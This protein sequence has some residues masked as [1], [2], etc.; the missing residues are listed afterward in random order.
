MFDSID[1]LLRNG[2]QK[3][4]INNRMMH[5]SF[6]KSFHSHA[7]LV[8]LF[9]PG[10]PGVPD[11]Y[12]LFLAKIHSDLSY[13]DI[14][15]PSYVEMILSL[16][17]LINQLVAFVGLLESYYPKDTKF[18]IAGHSLGSYLTVQIMKRKPNFNV[19]KIISLFPS[20][21][22]MAETPRGLQIAPITERIPRTLISVLAWSLGC[23]PQRTLKSIVWIVTGLPEHAVDAISKHLLVHDHA[24]SALYL[25]HSEMQGIRELEVE[26]MQ[27]YQHIWLIYFGKAD[28]WC[29]DFHIVDI[30]DR[31]ELDSV[32]CVENIDH[33]FV[34]HDSY[35]MAKKM[36]DWLKVIDF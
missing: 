16:E 14:W 18:V 32:L 27:K 36:V 4:L 26:I 34:L 7:K 12:E 8:L 31:L 19:V 13:L 17:E 20:L 33:A 23:I 2:R 21:Q 22:Q 24:K 35:K 30:S 29:P 11:F 9:L 5:F 15:C 28:G 6:K 3:A 10:N 25:G 1:F